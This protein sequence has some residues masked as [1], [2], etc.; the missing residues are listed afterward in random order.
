MT[1]VV[2]VCS[3][4]IK[5]DKIHFGSKIGFQRIIPPLFFE[6]IS[7]CIQHANTIRLL[8]PPAQQKK[9]MQ[10]EKFEVMTVK[11]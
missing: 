11:I 8:N 2:A 4:P 3:G 10:Y 7:G 9:Q 1:A 5:A 6:M